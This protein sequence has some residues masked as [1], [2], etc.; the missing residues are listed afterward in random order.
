MKI[1]KLLSKKKFL[2]LLIILAGF[3]SKA[4]D[5]PVDIW[6]IDKKKKGKNFSSEPLIIQ[7]EKKKID[8]NSLNIYE[9]QSQKISTIELNQAVDSQEIKI[10]GLYD[11]QDY[12]LDINMWSNSNGNQLK[13]IFSKLMKINLSKDANDIIKISMLTNAYLPENDISKKEFLKF[14]SDWLIKYSNLDLI[15]E[16]ITKNKIINLS[17]ELAKY[18]VNEHLSDANINKACEFFSKNLE[19]IDDEYLLKFKIYCL[20]EMGKKDEAQLVLDLKKEIGFKDEYFEKK[21]RF[22]DW[23]FR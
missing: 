4:E 19:P 14:K 7:N 22:L 20:V 13:S 12:G 9:M 21:N 5:K 8:T 15:E 3:N 11:P 6:N 2:I 23:L 10:I 18:L 16:Y 17:P 1:L